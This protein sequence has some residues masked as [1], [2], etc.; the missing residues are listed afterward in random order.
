MLCRALGGKVGKA[1]TGW[2]IGLRK[3][4][5]V[6]DLSAYRFLEDSEE[7]PPFLSIIECHQDEVTSLSFIFSPSKHPIS[8]SL[9]TLKS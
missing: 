5:I 6:K 8:L 9:K 3:V 2:D 1:Y 7:I 4:R